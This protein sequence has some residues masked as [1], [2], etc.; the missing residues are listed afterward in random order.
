MTSNYKTARALRVF[1]IAVLLGVAVTGCATKRRLLEFEIRRLEGQVAYLSE[2]NRYL[3]QNP[4]P[5]T[6]G[7]LRAFI[8]SDDLNGVLARLDD[9][10]VE[11]PTMPGTIIGLDHVR[12]NFKPGF[13]ELTTSAWARRDNLTVTLQ[14]AAALDFQLVPGDPDRATLRIHVLDVLPNVTWNP[15][16]FRVRGF[17]R[18]LL[19]LKAADLA[20]QLPMDS[21]PVAFPIDVPIKGQTTVVETKTEAGG[22]LRVEVVSPNLGIAGRGRLAARIF[23]PNG[24]H[25]IIDF[26]RP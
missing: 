3:D 7:S 20:A 6:A 10:R 14:V 8:R 17:A 26:V 15:L 2:L 5:H 13:P 21:F 16:A 1:A 18:D 4:Q 24:V 25:L 12:V 22:L 19:K 9:L 11:V 23:L